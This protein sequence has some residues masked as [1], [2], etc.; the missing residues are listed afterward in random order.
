MKRHI[1]IGI[2]Y[3]LL[4]Q[5]SKSWGIA[6]SSEFEDYKNRL[7]NNERMH[8]REN[9]FKS[10]TL[11][12]LQYL[13][14]S[15]PDDVE[16]KVFILT[17]EQ[18]PEINR[19]FILDVANKNKFVELKFYPSEKVNLNS[20]LVDYVNESVENNEPYASV[21]L[22]DDDGLSIAWLQET[23]K[24]LQP[25]FGNMMLSLSNG[26]AVLV[27]K[28]GMIEK[29]SNYKYRLLGAG[30]TY[31]GVKEHSIKSV[32]QCG[33]HTKVDERLPTIIYAKGNFF[34]RTFSGFNDSGK[35]FPDKLPVENI[36][37]SSVLEPFGLSN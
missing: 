24:F 22:D 27:N 25:C 5:E 10:I 20:H 9:I 28:A 31:I 8:A 6:R 26:L 3:S 34:I 16:F 32:Y 13:N 4:I 7:F 35:D 15:K 37:Y 17:S 1:I 18:L 14:E 11:K 19:K 30:L 36:D 2:R 21:R 23:V 29:I 33:S 12:S